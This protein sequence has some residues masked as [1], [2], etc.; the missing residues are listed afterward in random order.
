MTRAQIFGHLAASFMRFVRSLLHRFLS[1][2]IIEQL[3]NVLLFE[4]MC[5]N[6]ERKC[7]WHSIQLASLKPPFTGE[8]FP[9]LR[10][11]VLSGRY[12]PIPRKYTDSLHK[13][14][15]QMLSVN[16]KSRL[17]AA[18]I[19]SSP[20]LRTKLQLDE[21]ATSF[22]HRYPSGQADLMKTIK[23]PMGNNLRKLGT[24][25]PKPC[26]PDVRPNSPSSW[27]VAEQVKQRSSLLQSTESTVVNYRMPYMGT[28]TGLSDDTLV[29]SKATYILKTAPRLS[30]ASITESKNNYNK[31]SSELHSH[32]PAIN[33]PQKVNYVVQSR[34][35]LLKRFLV[36]QQP[37]GLP[38]PSQVCL[39][40]IFIGYFLDRPHI[41]LIVIH[42]VLLLLRHQDSMR[43][44][45]MSHYRELVRLVVIDLSIVGSGSHVRRVG[46]M[47][48]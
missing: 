12:P 46:L 32:D 8:S 30:L 28:A 24:V 42:F 33:V 9:A 39:V 22:G 34:P 47:F 2:C 23:V 7:I 17:S 41:R 16:P 14:I 1:M 26:Y 13:I 40:I 21:I 11:N 45:N 20:D 35:A 36:P 44:A 38:L 4:K 18:A 25:L 10:R 6:P 37:S 29:G 5:L 27:T 3:A 48:A 31:P 19:L 43:G 15:A